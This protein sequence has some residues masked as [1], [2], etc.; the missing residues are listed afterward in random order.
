M[1]FVIMSVS[2]DTE[3]ALHDAEADADALFEAGSCTEVDVG[4]A[5]FVPSTSGCYELHFDTSADTSTY[6]IDVSGAD[7]IVIFTEHN[8]VEFES[9]THFLLTAAGE[10]IEAEHTVPE[11][12]DDGHAGHDHGGSEDD[13]HAGHDHGGGDEPYEWAGIFDVSSVDSIQWVAQKVGGW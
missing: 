10:D 3:E 7:H 2:E 11:G 6:D 5:A 9:D 4:D 12:D 13:A 1:L 8:P